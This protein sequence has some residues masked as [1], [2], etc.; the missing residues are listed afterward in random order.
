MRVHKNH[1]EGLAGSAQRP[2][3]DGTYRLG[4]KFTA[5]FLPCYEHCAIKVRAKRK[6][7][8]NSKSSCLWRESERGKGRSSLLKRQS[9]RHTDPDIHLR[10]TTTL[11][12]EEEESHCFHS[13]LHSLKSDREVSGKSKQQVCGV[14]LDLQA[15]F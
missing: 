14:S 15:S 11:V 7:K 9:A 5:P 1:P 13:L 8:P 2:V 4:D 12:E 3:R 10:Q 6:N